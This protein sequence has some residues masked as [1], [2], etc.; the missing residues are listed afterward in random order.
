M[1]EP[2][3]RRIDRVLAAGFTKH[4]ARRTTEQ[5]QHMRE[6]AEAAHNEVYYEWCYFRGVIDILGEERLRRSSESDEGLISRLPETLAGK[7]EIADPPAPAASVFSVPDSAGSPRR[8]WEDRLPEEILSQVARLSS[9]E[10][11]WE[12]KHLDE[13]EQ[14]LSDRAKRVADVCDLIVAEQNR[15]RYT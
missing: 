12:I 2:R 3:R 14:E 13:Y 8:R 10:I 15:R 11:Q 4:L 1:T 9:D 5:L 7:P 6:E